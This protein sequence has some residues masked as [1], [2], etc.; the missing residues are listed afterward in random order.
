MTSRFVRRLCACPALSLTLT[1][2]GSTVD[3]FNFSV[4]Q[5]TVNLGQYVTLTATGFTL[6]TDA[7]ATR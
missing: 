7:S 2:T 4:G 3:N 5:L 1:F 6:N